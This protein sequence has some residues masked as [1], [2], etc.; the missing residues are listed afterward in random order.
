MIK[1][2]TEVQNE[3]SILASK[4]S[5]SENGSRTADEELRFQELSQELSALDMT[6]KAMSG[7]GGSAL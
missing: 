5:L 3:L 1:R 7:N 2:M 4:G 6:L